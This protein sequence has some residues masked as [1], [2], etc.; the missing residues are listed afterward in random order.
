MLFLGI[1]ATIHEVQ[2]LREQI[3]GFTLREDFLEML[4]QVPRRTDVLCTLRSTLPQK[5]RDL[6]RGD[7]LWVQ[8][9]NQC[10]AQEVSQA[11]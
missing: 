1:A 9:L 4:F 11:R 3:A 10:G 8:E 2:Q 6:L 7:V 5:I